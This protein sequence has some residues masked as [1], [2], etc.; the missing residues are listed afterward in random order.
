MYNKPKHLLLITATI[1]PKSN[2]KNLAVVDPAIRMQQYLLAFE[3]FLSLLQSNHIKNIVFVDNSATDCSPL[4]SLVEQHG[5]TD[6]VEVISFDGLD[7]PAEYGRGYGEFKLVQYAHDHSALM[8]TLADTDIV[9]KVTGRYQLTNLISMI[10]KAPAHFSIYCNCR[11]YPMYWVDKY[12]IAWTKAAYHASLNNI[13]KQ[14][15][16]TREASAELKFRQFIDQL[17]SKNVI[18]RFNVTPHLIGYRGYDN[19]PYESGMK[20]HLRNML[21]KVMPF[22]WI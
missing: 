18:K 19:Q 17:T 16:E 21:N 4:I 20:F 1:T 3:F 2:A 9:W 7:Y 11:N 6:L 5:L 14:L 22:I 10:K 8:R 15:I 12:V 13:Y